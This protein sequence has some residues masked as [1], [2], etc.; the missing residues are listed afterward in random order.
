MRLRTVGLA[1]ALSALSSAAL[2]PAAAA[3]EEDAPRAATH[4]VGTFD[5]SMLRIYVNGRPEGGASTGLP[6][7][8]GD[9]PV[10]IGSFY[11]G[12]RWFGVLDEVA[13]YD[14]ALSPEDVRRHHELGSGARDGDYRRRTC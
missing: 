6:R 14:R 3:Q 7:R 12:Q 13:L 10:E 1:L 5:G 4:V 11:G 8:P 9:V 2:A